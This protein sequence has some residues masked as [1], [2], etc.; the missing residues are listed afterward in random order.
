MVITITKISKSYGMHPVLKGVSFT[1]NAGERIGLVGANGVGKSTLL[2]ILTG[3]LSADEGSI[4]LADGVRLGYLAQVITAAE[5]QTFGD[6][7]ASA[8]SRVRELEA[9][10][11]ALADELT[12]ASGDALNTAL[13]AY[14]EVSEQFER[15]GGYEAEAQAEAVL[16]GLGVGHLPRDRTLATLSGGE[17]TR[18]AL[19]LLLL[20]TPDVLLLDEPTN[21][22]DFASLDWLEGYLSAYR[23]AAL[24]VSHDR[25]FLNRTV[26]AIVEIEEHERTAK[27]YTGDYDAYHAAKQ[28]ERRTWEQ[29]YERQQEEIRAL[30]LE[31]KETS[32]RNNNYRPH[33]D[34][35]KFVRNDKIATHAHTVSRR[36]RAAEE[37]L[38]RL[39][40][41]PIPQP[42]APLRFDPRFDPDALRGHLPL[43]ISGIGHAFGER[44]ILRD[45]SFTVGPH[46]RIV[47]AGPNGAGKSTL[48]KIIA[49]I[50]WADCG[51]V[52]RNPAVRI[53][54]LDQEGMTF[55]PTLT[56]FEAYSVGLEGSEQQRKTALIKSGMFRYED[57]G[58]PVSGLSSGQRRKLQIA[59]LIGEHSNLL[60][61]DEPTN[62]VSF[63]VL[64]G[65]EAALRE[66]PGP[67]IAATHDRRFMQGFGGEIYA[68][69]DG[70]MQTYLG[71]YEDY[72]TAQ[73]RS[74]TAGFLLG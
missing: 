63:D 27:R 37:K 53:G 74:V 61:L 16:N 26:T 36:V 8:Q 51:S 50:E 34:A 42:P 45:V 66:F 62:Y 15:A 9:Q 58:R 67:I 71:G 43:V 35:D 44:V 57:F 14:G 40:A 19:A 49:G 72:M 25:H 6:M 38:D 69:A 3:E 20:D 54:Y 21:H 17:K 46:S 41:N 48:L 23:G 31:A 30:T 12:R 24:I 13:V 29:N 59:R 7:I 65:L 1:L 47:L 22:L 52:Y 2:K 56:L 11:H 10:M 32:R 73:P 18:A 5:G 55:D 60:L 64:E 68:L 39:L 33:T 4:T 70:T 28:K